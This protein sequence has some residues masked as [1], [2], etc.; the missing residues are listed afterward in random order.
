MVFILSHMVPSDPVV[1]NL[2][3]RNMSNPELVEIFRAK[4]GLDKPLHIQYLVYMKSLLKG[5]LGESIRT[6]RPIYSNS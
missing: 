1:A 6:G 3:Q 4:W 5:D 2:S